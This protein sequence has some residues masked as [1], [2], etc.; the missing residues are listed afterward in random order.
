[1]HP[2]PPLDG[3]AHPKYA[4]S[5]D[6]LCRTAAALFEVSHVGVSLIDQHGRWVEVGRTLDAHAGPEADA[7][8]ARVA[9]SDD[10]VLVEGALADPRHADGADAQGSPR[11]GFR[12]GAHIVTAPGVHAG[13]LVLLDALPRAFSA[14]ACRQLQ[15]LAS[16][17]AIPL[18]LIEAERRADER[19]ALM[20]AEVRALK[21]AEAWSRVGHWRIAFP[22]ETITWSDGMYAVFGRDPRLGP[23]PKDAVLDVFHPDDREEVRVRLERTAQGLG[24]YHHRPRLIRPDGEVR[25]V[26]AHAYPERDQAGAV[27]GLFGLCM[28]VSDLVRSEARVREASD[29]LRAT[30]ES[31]QQGLVVLDGEQRVRLLNRRSGALLALPA[32]VLHEGAAFQDIRAHQRAR[33][34]FDAVPPDLR[35]EMEATD[36]QRLPPI[37]DWP[38]PSGVVLGVRRAPLANGGTVTTF[39]D[40]T[41][42]RLNERAVQES[43]QR[44]RLLAE[45][46]TDVIIWCDLDTTR[47]YVSPAVRSVL[48]YEP[49]DLVGT[50]PLGF[51]HPDDVEQ[52]RCLLDEL[53]TG[54]IERADTTQRYRRKGGGW[55]WIEVSFKLARGSDGAATSYVAALRDVSE[56]RAV[57][58]RFRL[59]EER[60]ALALDSG[61][62][63]LWDWDLATGA[64]AL[65]SHWFGM[66]GYAADEIEPH[67]R[68]WEGLV[69][70]GDVER[71]RRLLVDHIKG[72]TPTYACEY[73]LRRKTGEYAWTLARG[74]VV[75]RD[76]AGRA[77]RIV[78]THMDIAARKEAERLI[79]HMAHHDS[80]TGL[81]NRALFRERLERHR[82]EVDQGGPGIA[83]LACDLDGFK[84]VNDRHGHPIGDLL[85]QAV[86]ERLRLAVREGDTVARLGGDEFAII[87]APLD[88]PRTAERVAKRVIEA[89]GEP[90]NLDGRT[91]S[92]GVSIGIAIDARDD[93][94]ANALYKRADL[95]LY[96]AKAAGR[97]TYSFH[98]PGTAAGTV[99]NDGTCANHAVA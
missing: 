96:S 10:A 63:G 34:D 32:S 79:A 98:R 6:A 61:S 23:P 74:K 25:T 60:L 50:R 49:E 3:T 27:V 22:G 29:L 24:D 15:D 66:L 91:A 5:L 54:R 51:L 57:E 85:L 28:D 84:G 81:P 4:P 8:R 35:A 73:R 77:M 37:Y 41:R 94:D 20:A 97:S 95:A 72:L 13:A 14:E 56:S 11:V 26:L 18:R 45:T 31:M 58:E 39:T 80:L 52:C 70:P 65:S 47:R 78:G 82:A 67:I 48:G 92:I 42:Q 83:V 87:L 46:P 86:A 7:F 19:E 59:R 9:R 2:P 33:G 30:V 76:G 71:S 68:A 16:I 64:V 69:H 90:F 1:M 89:L 62:D 40:V 38:L 12:A 36:L 55:V 53:V 75:A 93:P 43:E 44:F 17:A 99:T 88:G 21:A